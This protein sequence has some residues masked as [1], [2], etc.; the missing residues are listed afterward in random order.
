MPSPGRHFW[1]PTLWRPRYGRPLRKAMRWPS[2][3]M[4]RS[5][6]SLSESRYPACRRSS[7]SGKNTVIVLPT[8]GIA[9]SSRPSPL[10]TRR[11]S[12]T[13]ARWRSGRA[14]IVV[15]DPENWLI[16]DGKLY[17]FGKQMGPDLF[18]RTSRG[19]SARPTRTGRP[20]EELAVGRRGRLGGRAFIESGFAQAV[21]QKCEIR[22]LQEFGPEVLRIECRVEAADYS[23]DTRAA[24]S[25][26]PF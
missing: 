7:T 4:I 21:T 1:R 20:A 23:G 2:R 9:T 6:I 24:S 11:S 3:A 12:E 22:R 5:P 14:K 19:T 15:A 13:T 18:R 25:A 26:W 10:V 17:V 16:S 8:P